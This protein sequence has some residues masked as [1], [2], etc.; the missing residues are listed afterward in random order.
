MTTQSLATGQKKS[1]DGSTAFS[2]LTWLKKKKQPQP[3][4]AKLYPLG[5]ERILHYNNY[6]MTEENLCLGIPLIP[7]FQTTP[8]REE[9]FPVFPRLFQSSRNY[10]SS[11][12]H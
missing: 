3:T 11:Y 12:I 9:I 4:S 6:L 2:R 5:G 7:S 1:Q 10:C 8:I